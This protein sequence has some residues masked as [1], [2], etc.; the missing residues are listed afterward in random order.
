MT[1]ELEGLSIGER[2]QMIRER[3]GKSRPVVA[4]L[5]GRSTEWLKAVERGRRGAPDIH[6]LIK[7]GEVLGVHDLSE[8]T[9]DETIRMGLERRSGHPVVD[10]LRDAIEAAVLSVPPGPAP[11]PESLL[12]RTAEAW[13][14]WHTSPAP[15][16]A[17]GA[18]LPQLIRD[19]RRAV[20]M[21][22][23]SG[24]RKAYI[25]LSG[26]YALSEQILAWVSDSAL[27]WLAADR[28]MDAAQQA[29]DPETMAS[30]AWVLGN[31]W[32]AT[33]REEE[34][35]TLVN[36][37][38]ALLEPWLGDG[39]DSTRALWGSC[40]LHAS[41][42]LARMGREG[43]ALR[44][45]DDAGAMA[46]RIPEQYAHPWT[47]FGRANAALT[48]VSVQVDLR[49]GGT[50]LEYASQMNPDDIPSIDRRSRLWLETSRAY[51][52]RGD[53]TSALAVLE[54]ATSISTESM[55]CHPLSRG[56]ASWL[57]TSGGRL[58]E[59][60]SRALAT[61]IGLNV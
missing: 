16:A 60:D 10:D 51:Q 6:M 11:D 18:V 2:I 44:G 54:K 59:R 20:R 57:V 40:R 21:L 22:D 7:L 23:G 38:A 36:D 8:L 58:V 33:G 49:K 50:A 15:R 1:D 27:L 43:D 30:A 52:Q 39:P 26:A 35:W 45:L 53:A 47:L 5:V 32:R 56:I 48:G 28:C 19:C 31:V 55:A 24:R 42:T 37:G 13:Q 34:A 14:L 3:K 46:D 25:A 61:R 12:T 41:I 29:D 4:G 9:G 17:A